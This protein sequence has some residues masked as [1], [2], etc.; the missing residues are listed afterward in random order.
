MLNT[1]HAIL[2]WL[3]SAAVLHSGSSVA[4]SADTFENLQ[5]AFDG[6]SNANAASWLSPGRLGKEEYGEVASL[7]R[8]VAKAEEIHARAI[9]RRQLF[10]NWALIWSHTSSILK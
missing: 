6:E 2:P 4:N 10:D 8:A 9:K 7:F 5:A 3:I 1:L